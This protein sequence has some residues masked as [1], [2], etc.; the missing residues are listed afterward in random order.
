MSDCGSMRPERRRRPRWRGAA[1]AA[2]LLAFAASTP[3][4]DE[5]RDP[6]RPPDHRQER[7]QPRFDASAWQL[8]STLVA[9]DRRIARINGQTVRSGDTVGGARVLAIN[10]GRVQLDYRGRKF[11]IRRSIPEVRIERGS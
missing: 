11:T 1:I 4:A 9:G 2:A 8:A 7:A 3:A 10:N 5:R 6:L